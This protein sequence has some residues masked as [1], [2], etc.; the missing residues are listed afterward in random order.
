MAEPVDGGR[1]D[2]VDAE[3]DRA[4]NRRDRVGVVLRPPAE[5]PV[6]AAN[7]PRAKADDR[8]VQVRV[9]KPPC[10]HLVNSSIPSGLVR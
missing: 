2:P 4:P 10:L 6:A 8:D 7:R 1:V 3:I 5:Q 9:P